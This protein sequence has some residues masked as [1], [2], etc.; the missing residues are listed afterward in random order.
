MKG[1]I[2]HY[3]NEDLIINTPVCNNIANGAF[4]NFY[5]DIPEY[6][7]VDYPISKRN[8][9]AQQ[10]LEEAGYSETNPLVFSISYSN[11]RKVVTDLAIFMKSNW[12]KALGNLVKISLKGSEWKLYL[13]EISNKNFE[14]CRFGTTAEYNYPGTYLAYLLGNSQFNANYRNPLIDELY[15]KS[16]QCHTIDEHLKIQGEIIKILMNDYVV[17]PMHT[18]FHRT[19]LQG[20][21]KGYYPEENPLNIVYSKDLEIVH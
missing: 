9:M 19:L 16:L 1:K 8:K 18:S 4:K 10:L 15:S 11:H 13:Q 21:L 6:S 20:Y 7:W 2:I 14:M 3:Y 5:K 12:E 17:I